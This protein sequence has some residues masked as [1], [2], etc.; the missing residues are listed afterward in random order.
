MGSP[1]SAAVIDE[2]ATACRRQPIR[3]LNTVDGARGEHQDSRR[4]PLFEFAR[5]LH[6]RL[7]PH[8]PRYER[9]Q[10]NIRISQVAGKDYPRMTRQQGGSFFALFKGVPFSDCTADANEFVDMVE[11]SRG[12]AAFTAIANALKKVLAERGSHFSTPGAPAANYSG[13]E[14]RRDVVLRS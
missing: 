1:L 2:A 12:L 4:D 7:D 6:S 13:T 10:R 11:G 5:E 8:D 14:E 3:W 9:L